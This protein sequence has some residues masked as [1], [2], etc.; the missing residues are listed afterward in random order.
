MIKALKQK[1]ADLVKEAQAIFDLSA[2]EDRNLTEAEAS[3][4]DAI[5]AELADLDQQITRAERQMDRQ[6]TVGVVLDGNADADRNDQQGR[7][8]EQRFA[9]LGEQMMAVARAGN[10]DFRGAADPRLV[11]SAGPTGASEGIASDGGFLVQTDFSNELLQ[12]TYEAGDIASR[13]RHIPIGAN[14]NGININGV[15]ETSRANGS[16]WGGIQSYWTGEAQLITASQPKFR[17]IKMEL[18]KLTGMCYAIR[19]SRVRRSKSRISTG[20]NAT[21]GSGLCLANPT[22]V[23]CPTSLPAS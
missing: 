7:G 22:K 20:S 23:L 1:R 17:R 10:P 3:R 11:L 12:N 16:R 18:D 15:D 8:G 13:V 21:T 14:A 2:K 6:R 19:S 5:S 9:S 4:D